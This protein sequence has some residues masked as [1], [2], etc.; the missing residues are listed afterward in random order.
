MQG[1]WTSATTYEGKLY[2]TKQAPWNPASFNANATQVT[3]VGMAKLTFTDVNR[4]T[5]EY[6]MKGVTG[7][8]LI[9]KFEF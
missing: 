7:K 1:S 9:E 2:Q 4:A 5:F 6:T 3:E 8:K